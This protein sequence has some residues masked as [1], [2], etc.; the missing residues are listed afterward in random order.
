MARPLGVLL[1]AALVAVSGCAGLNE[2]NNRGSGGG[3]GAPPVISAQS[4][5]S[6]ATAELGIPVTATRNTTRVPGADPVADVAGAVSAVFPS[7]APDN[8]PKA[9]A[10][11]DKNNWQGAIS[12]SVLMADPLGIPI[13][14][15][16]DG[17]L[18]AVSSDALKRLQP[19][20]SPLAQN[21]QIIRIGD[22]AA[23][24]SGYRTAVVPG[25]DPYGI[26]AGIDRFFS[27]ARAKPTRDVVVTSG[28]QSG[29]AM[30]ASAWA[31]RSG[32]SVLFVKQ[33]AIPAFTRSALRRHSHA[34][35]YLLGPPTAVSSAVAKSLGHFGKVTRIDG[36]TPV[37][38]AIA[39]TR[40]SSHGFGWGITTPGQNFTIAG[41]S[42]PA[43]AA[44]GAVL[45]T[46]GVYAPLL[47]TDRSATL[48]TPL[49]NYFLDVQPGFQTNPNSGVF[50]HVWILGDDSVV[51][52]AAQGRLDSITQL[53]PVQNQQP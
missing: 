20:G 14:L 31:A 40:Y 53:V 21:A 30:P 32:D 51:S 10:I 34:H 37:E 19:T 22:N 16:D 13:L 28:E 24:V 25:T 26:A 47:L 46:A 42:R 1:V 4:G 35:I 52:V 38:N 48:P 6:S 33:N 29:F 27:V 43:D 5:S 44:A 12:A 17:K 9:V 36:V 18:P 8:R 39:F 2:K 15:S 50:N 23:Q 49:D 11:V 41:T 45:G 7:T 3:G